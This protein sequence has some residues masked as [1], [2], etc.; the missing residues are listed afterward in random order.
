MFAASAGNGII[1]TI[2]AP[3]WQEWNLS[4]QQELNRSTVF[5]V[6][7]V[8]NHG[9][10]ITYSNAWP[11]AYRRV[12]ACIEGTLPSAPPPTTIAT[13]TQYKQGAV[14]NYNGLTFSLRKQFS[15]LGIGSRELHLVAQHRRNL[16]R[17]PVPVWLRRQQH[18][19]GPDLPEPVCARIN[20]GN[21]D[22]DIRHLVNADFVFNPEFHK[23]GG[24]KYLVNGWQFSGKM[25]WRT[26]L[27]YTISDGN[28]AGTIIN[29]GDTIPATIIGN[30]QPGGCGRGKCEL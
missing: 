1:G 6:N 26:G 7:Y 19:S 21:S 8:G 28:L 23:T 30:A 29:G 17:W 15:Q 4:V 5:I 16:E 18:H 20:Y 24:L 22:Y 11:N 3:E 10:R 14:S 2:K 9:A 25:F 12:M 13:V 27:P